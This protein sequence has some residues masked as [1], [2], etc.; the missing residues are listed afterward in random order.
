VAA[1]R[2]PATHADVTQKEE[3][4]VV[5]ALK[6]AAKQGDVAAAREL[7]AWRDAAAARGATTQDYDLAETYEELGAE[8]RARLRKRLLAEAIELDKQALTEG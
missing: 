7:R 3:D 2:Q 5:L 4:A 6:R 8:T 1:A